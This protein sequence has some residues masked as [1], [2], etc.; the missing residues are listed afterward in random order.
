MG[1]AMGVRLKAALKSPGNYA[2]HQR[3]RRDG[4][5]LSTDFVNIDV[6]A[7]NSRGD[8]RSQQP[9]PYQH[10]ER[11]LAAF[12]NACRQSPSHTA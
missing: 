6:A 1:A 9:L 11:S 10:R 2:L 7:I 5:L 12:P 3:S 8:G 4:V